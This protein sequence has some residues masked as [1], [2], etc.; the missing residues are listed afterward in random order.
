ML[1]KALDPLTPGVDKG[2][3]K[4]KKGEGRPAA[5]QRDTKNE[6]CPRLVSGAKCS[7][8]DQR[9]WY[10][11]DKDKIKAA[12]RKKDT[13]FVLVLLNTY[14]ILAARKG[15]SAKTRVSSPTNAPDTNRK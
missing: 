9:C 13:P 2:R 10:S 3:G 5:P 1:P 8:G 11:H 14:V 4:G 6:A 15:G 7:F 12:K